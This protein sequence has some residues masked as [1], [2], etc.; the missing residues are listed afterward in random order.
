VILLSYAS[1][2]YLA[3]SGT[4]SDVLFYPRYALPIIVVLT[5]LAGR[6]LSDLIVFIPRWR[7]TASVVLIVA[8]V[9]WP[10]TE[11][12]RDTYS[13][14][15]TDTRTLAKEWFEANVPAGSKVL[16]EGGKIAASRITVPLVDSRES[17]EQR[18]EYWKVKEP[19][20]AKF[21]ELKRAVHDGGG[22]DLELVQIGSIAPLGDYVARGIEYFIV[23]P[24]FFLASRMARGD[25]ARL[26]SALRTDM[27]VKLLRRFEAGSRTRP[28]PTIEIY[29]IQ[30]GVAPS[31]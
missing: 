29:Q 7:M 11:A 20:Q 30:P 14:T 2:N 21:L 4:S 23:R 6:T 18:I 27:R 8:L 15:Q 22:Y 31:G 24:D 3:I 26:L 1:I 12:I 9:A 16:I 25:S 28:G 10:V 17:L 13:L 5:V 19:R